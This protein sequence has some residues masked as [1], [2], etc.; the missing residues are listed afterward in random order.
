MIEE[1]EKRAR[2]RFPDFAIS[3]DAPIDKENGIFWID[4]AKDEKLFAI[5]TWVGRVQKI[6]I[7]YKED[8]G[9]GPPGDVFFEKE[10]LE[11]AL[12]FLHDFL[13]KNPT[14]SL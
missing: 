13:Q 7:C 2:E 3:V 6:G 4:L 8:L 5:I 14:H 10:Q 12:S 11:E 9:F 1:I